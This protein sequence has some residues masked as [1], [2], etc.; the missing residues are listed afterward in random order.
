MPGTGPGAVTSP[1]SATR[2]HYQVAWTVS[3]AATISPLQISLDEIPVIVTVV[4]RMPFKTYKFTVKSYCHN[5]R[6]NGT[7]LGMPYLY[8]QDLLRNQCL[9]MMPLYCL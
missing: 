9:A 2:H 6:S 8:T 4:N 7:L 1:A 5:H 3:R